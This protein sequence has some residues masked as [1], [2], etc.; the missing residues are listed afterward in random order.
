MKCGSRTHRESTAGSRRLSRT[1]ASACPRSHVDWR[2]PSAEIRAE[3]LLQGQGCPD[4][5]R[6]MSGVLE[7]HDASDLHQRS[8]DRGLHWAHGASTDG[9]RR[10]L[11]STTCTARRSRSFASSAS[12]SKA[13]PRS[14]G[15]GPGASLDCQTQRIEIAMMRT[16]DG[17]EPDRALSGYSRRRRLPITGTPR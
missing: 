11:S 13:K 8:N 16:P 2:E 14:K 15:N 3:E 10:A 7:D 1:P 17:H 4:Q 5:R 12:S 9:R 6:R